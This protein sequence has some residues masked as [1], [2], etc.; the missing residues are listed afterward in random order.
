MAN[1]KNALDKMDSVFS[2]WY[3]EDPMLTMAWCIVEKISDKN[4]KT[5]GIDSRSLPPQIRFNPNFINSLSYEVLEMIMAS[6]SFKLLLRHATNRLQNPKDVCALSSQITIDEIMKK[7][8]EK[9]PELKKVLMSAKDFNLPENSYL[10]DYHRRL[11]DNED[12]MNQQLD[13]MFGKFEEGDEE[14]DQDKDEDGYSKFGGQGDAI[15]EYLDPRNGDNKNWGENS[16]LDGEIKYLV[17]NYKNS[18]KAWGKFSGDA[19]SSIVA[20]NTP[21]ISA[22]EW[23]R[24][25]NTS[26]TSTAQFLTRMKPNRRFDLEAQ[27]KKRKYITKVLFAIDSSGSMSDEDLAEGFAV[28]NSAVKHAEIH[29]LLW[30]TEIKYIE[31]KFKKAKKEFKVHGRGGT[32]PELVLKYAEENSYDGVV[33]FSDMEFSDNLRAPR[34]TKVLWLGT[35][36][37]SKKPVS[38]GYWATLDRN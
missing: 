30:D 12:K 13:K 34:S 38:F 1:T 24:R 6:E 14:S 18:A 3:L 26:I 23:L 29:Y 2:N 5:I 15:K 36:K 27:G 16:N 32:N 37:N 22:R 21:K 8:A 19:I 11:R 31:K 28:V 35:E 9:I 25:F 10:E 33:I 7:N 17:D 20:A 4:Q